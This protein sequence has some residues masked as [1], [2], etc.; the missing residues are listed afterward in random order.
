MV[1]RQALTNYLFE[2][3]GLQ[4]VRKYHKMSNGFSL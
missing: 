2:G 3:D 4:A 1:I